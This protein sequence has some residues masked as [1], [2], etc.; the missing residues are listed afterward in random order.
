MAWSVDDNM[1]RVWAYEIQRRLTLPLNTNPWVS[2][3]TTVATTFEVEDTAGISHEYR[4]IPIPA[5]TREPDYEKASG[6]VRNPNVPRMVCFN[7]D[8]HPNY[9]NVSHWNLYQDIMNEGNDADFEPRTWDVFGQ[10]SYALP[11]VGLDPDG[12]Y[13]QRA[14]YFSHRLDQTV[15]VANPNESCNVIDLRTN[16][17]ADRVRPQYANKLT[18]DAVVET[19]HHN[20]PVVWG[21]YGWRA[22][23]FTDNDLPAGRYGIQYRVCPS[24]GGKCSYWRDSGIHNVGIDTYP[25]TAPAPDVTH[26]ER[27][28]EGL[29]DFKTPSSPHLGPE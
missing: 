19:L 29:M 16:R 27:N 3:G 23:T 8:T 14:F 4:V 5:G 10:D 26:K 28:Y 1:G 25:F 9:R 21:V 2:L 15:C 22:I 18:E 24:A 11:C 6:R 7:P 12:L 17:E 20:R 13:L